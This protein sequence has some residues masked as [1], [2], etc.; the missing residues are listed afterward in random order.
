MFDPLGLIEPVR[1]SFKVIWSEATAAMK[2]D[3]W[4]SKVPEEFVFKWSNLYAKIPQHLQVTR[5]TGE[6]EKYRIYI[7]ASMN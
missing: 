2:N 6:P 1:A 7:D 3:N 4:K 5:F